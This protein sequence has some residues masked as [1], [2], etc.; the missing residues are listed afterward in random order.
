MPNPVLFS[1]HQQ[2]PK[3]L[4]WVIILPEALILALVVIQ[5]VYQALQTHKSIAST[6]LLVPLVIVCVVTIL[7]V[8]FV[9]AAKL[10]TTVSDDGM[11]IRW[12]PLQLHPVKI[13]LDNAVSVTAMTY[14]ALRD[15]GGWGIRYGLHGMIYNMQGNKAICITYQQGKKLMIGTQRPDELLA[16]VKMI[17]KPGVQIG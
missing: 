4:N 3:W 17:C 6:D 5:S 10:V 11:S 16:A 15:F 1:E 2:L 7:P 9:L 14:N 8:V 13:D 12:I